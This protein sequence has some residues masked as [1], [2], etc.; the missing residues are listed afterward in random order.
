MATG[1]PELRRQ[2]KKLGIK[3]VKSM[4]GDELRAAIAA[5]GTAATPVR[6]KAVKRAVSKRARASTSA[7]AKKKTAKR[8]NSDAPARKQS[9]GGRTTSARTAPARG[10]KSGGRHM[11]GSLDF[12]R[13]KGWNP[14]SGSAIE[15]IFKALKKRN[16]NVEKVFNDLVGDI[17]DFV[18][19]RKTNGD[20]RTKVEMERFLRYRINRVKFDFAVKTGQHKPSTNRATYGEGGTG[21][22]GWKR[23]MSTKAIGRKPA[24]AAK[25]TTAKAAPPAK[26]RGRGRPKGSKNRKK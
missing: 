19:R 13:T 2:A 16:G 4:T 14:Q 6:K 15:R 25:K 9:R 7:P 8:R 20:T 10:A 26:K 11:L 12:T 23:G 22:A 1:L 21:S 17:K 3:G 18:P 5:N 24:R